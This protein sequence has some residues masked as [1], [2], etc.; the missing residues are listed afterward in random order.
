MHCWA[1]HLSSRALVPMARAM[2]EFGVA[3]TVTV[4]T[5]LLALTGLAGRLAELLVHAVGAVA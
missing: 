3:L 1:G 2:G 4:V 5:V